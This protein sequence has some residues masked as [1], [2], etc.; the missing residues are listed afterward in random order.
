VPAPTKLPIPAPTQLPVPAPTQLP[1]P[2]PAKL[3]IPNPTNL[4]SPPPSLTL[5][6]PV[7]APSQRPSADPTELLPAPSE[8]E[9]EPE[10]EPEPSKKAGKA[11]SSL[12]VIVAIS[13]VAIFAFGI[14]C[15]AGR[16]F[17]HETVR[18]KS[19]NTLMQSDSYPCMCIFLC[20]AVFLFISTDD[21]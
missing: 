19:F 20:P 5:G 6:L 17:I 1:V 15:F 12:T 11:D 16:G 10:P 4:P 13:G 2:A 14:A 3:P 18:C 8:V 9:P 7:A 21:P